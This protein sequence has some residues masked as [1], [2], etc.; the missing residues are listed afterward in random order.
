MIHTLN[1]DHFGI[2]FAP[3]E[4]ATVGGWVRALTAIAEHERGESL[5]GQ[6]VFVRA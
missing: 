1:Q 6:V 5:C 3:H 4:R 2:V